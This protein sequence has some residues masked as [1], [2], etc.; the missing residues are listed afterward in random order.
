MLAKN[1]NEVASN[2]QVEDRNEVTA[3]N[4]IYY[5]EDQDIDSDSEN[6]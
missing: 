1:P 4:I 6:I 5:R 2:M 3:E